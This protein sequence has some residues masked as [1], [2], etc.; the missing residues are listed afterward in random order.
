LASASYEAAGGIEIH[1]PAKSEGLLGRLWARPAIRFLILAYA[2]GL[3]LAVGALVAKTDFVDRLQRRFAGSVSQTE[4]DNVYHRWAA[5]F[6]RGDARARPGALVFLG[7]SIMRDLD[8]SSI[9]RHTLN[10]AIPG[11]TTSRL[12]KRIEEYRSVKTARGVVLGVGIND[13]FWRPVPEIV[14]NYREILASVPERVPVLLTAVLPVDERVQ[15]IFRNADI[16]RLN[17]AL[18]EMC[19][20][21]PGCRFMDPSPRMIDD[22]G[23]LRADDHEGD[24]IH[25][26]NVGHEAYWKSMNAAVLAEM[27]PAVVVAPAE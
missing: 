15:P 4:F 6:A 11:E 19:D 25:L 27:P 26:S 14:G 12:L 21:R 18:R 20:A 3:H 1:R 24:G 16:R 17:G 23:N 2:V 22:T 10:L 7:D 8:T 13:L 5:A 9:A